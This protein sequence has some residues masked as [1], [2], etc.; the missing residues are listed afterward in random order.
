[1]NYSVT[2]LKHLVL[3]YSLHYQI[4]LIAKPLS[5]ILIT[6][7]YYSTISF[8]K[9]TSYNDKNF[10]DNLILG[11]YNKKTQQ[12]DIEFQTIVRHIL[13]DLTR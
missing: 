13:Y 11:D 8:E 3:Y 7:P 12:V 1:M 4:N 5:S 6:S 9:I 10:R 2:S